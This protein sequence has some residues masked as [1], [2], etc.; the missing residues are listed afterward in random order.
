LKGAS[1]MLDE[2]VLY[3]PVRHLAERI[4][5]RQLSPVELAESYLSRSEQWNP[6]L[7]AYVTLTRE[8]AMEQARAAEKE[9][10]TGNY[11]GPPHGIRAPEMTRRHCR[12][13]TCCRRIPIGTLDTPR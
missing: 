8:L 12:R 6:R 7:N 1:K 5:K 9:I 4:R 11:R 2:S 13:P 10:A 3:L